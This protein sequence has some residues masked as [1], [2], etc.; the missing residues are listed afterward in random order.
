MGLVSDSTESVQL[1]PAVSFP[2]LTA[3]ED[4]HV[5]YNKSGRIEHPSIYSCV[6]LPSKSSRKRQHYTYRSPKVP[7]TN[8]S[9]I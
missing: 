1:P 2:L 5:Q 3:L 7:H 8:Y 6:P 4:G 9:V